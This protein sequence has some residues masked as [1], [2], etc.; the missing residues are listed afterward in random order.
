MRLAFEPVRFPRGYA[1]VL[2]VAAM[3]LRGRSRAAAT[4]G[5]APEAEAELEAG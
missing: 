4:V 1:A 2:E 5:A 3:A